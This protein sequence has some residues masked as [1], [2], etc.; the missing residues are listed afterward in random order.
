MRATRHVAAVVAVAALPAT[1]AE[2]TRCGWLGNPT[3]A[4]WFLDDADGVW[5]LSVQGG[6]VADGFYDLPPGDPALVDEWVSSNGEPGRSS[7]GYGCAC[8]TGM[9]D[10]ATGHVLSAS[11][12]ETLRLSRCRADPNLPAE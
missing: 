8:V 3:P 4:N 2:Q 1:A 11:A 10:A 9:F 7:Y 5:T 12:M 6:W